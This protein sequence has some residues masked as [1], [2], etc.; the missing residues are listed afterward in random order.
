[1]HAPTAPWDIGAQTQHGGLQSTCKVT[2]SLNSEASGEVKSKK[3]GACAL[4]GLSGRKESKGEVSGPVRIQGTTSLKDTQSLPL[5]PSEHKS[6]EE[7]RQGRTDGRGLGTT[8]PVNHP[9]PQNEQE[10]ILFEVPTNQ[11][12]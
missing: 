11:H 5:P 2:W 4:Q 1:M 8:G 6:T 12:S 10:E 7:T 3:E 9:N